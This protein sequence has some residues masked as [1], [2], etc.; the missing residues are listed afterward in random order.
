MTERHER[1]EEL[2]AGHVLRALDEEDAREVEVLL[3]EHLPSCETCREAWRELQQTAGELALA[4]PPSA[5][6]QLLLSRMH[7]EI[8]DRP[9]PHRR[10]VGSWLGTAAAVAVIGLTAWNAALNSRLS[11]AVDENHRFATAMNFI[12]QPDSRKVAFDTHNSRVSANLLAAYQEAHVELVGTQVPDPAAGD[13]YRLWVGR[14][15][16]FFLQ[17]EFVP[18]DGLVVLSFLVDVSRPD[19]IL[20]TEEPSDQPGAAPQGRRRWFATIERAAA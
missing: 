15:G 8:R 13:V 19:Q 10:S 7:R 6:P 17:Q 14:G 1:I 11:D 3:A 20:I 12:A 2:L 18:H 4:A 9:A 5:P 16:R